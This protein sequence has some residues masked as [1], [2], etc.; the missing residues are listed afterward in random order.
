MRSIERFYDLLSY[1]TIDTW[2]NQV[3]NLGRDFGYEKTLLAIFPDCNS[4][5]EAEYAFL[6]SSYSVEW[7]NKY[8]ELKLGHLDPTVSHC[9]I[10]STPLI[11]TPEIFSAR[12]QKEMYEE[13]C[14]YGLKSGVTLPIHGARG[15]LGIL[16]F[17][18]DVKPS[19]NF[20]R[21]AIHSF[22]ELSC[23]RDFIFE[24][25][26]KFINDAR[27]KK[28]FTHITNR[29][30][31]CLKWSAAGKSSWEIGELLH[32]TE[33]TVNFHFSNIRRKLNSR[34]RQQAIV[35]AISLGLINPS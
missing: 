24:S 1:N 16:C 10:H 9:L 5:M 30:L 27:P 18:N 8:D 14:G 20:K 28:E 6:H 34:S 26:L 15:E 17:V 4:P 22:S 25:A 35:R 12:R 7:R 33:A 13:A 19:V 3:F 2:R 21:H 31:E 11:W 23:F 32:C 29:E